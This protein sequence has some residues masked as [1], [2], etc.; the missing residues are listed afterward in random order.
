MAYGVHC[1]SPIVTC[2]RGGVVTI[3]SVPVRFLERYIFEAPGVP[4]PVVTV[5]EG[6]VVTIPSVPVRSW[7]WLTGS[8]GLLL[9]AHVAEGGVV[10]IPSACRARMPPR[11]QG[12][13]SFPRWALPVAPVAGRGSCDNSLRSCAVL[14]MAYGVHWAA[15]IG[16]CSRGGSCDNSL[17][18]PGQDAS[19]A[20]RAPVL[21]PLGSSCGACSREGEL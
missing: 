2:S 16:T 9:L 8:T 17:R 14:G 3:P 13:R 7:G 1:A 20:P 6:G 19:K 4:D 15:P 10:T 18:L 21:P 5:T 11:P 12:R